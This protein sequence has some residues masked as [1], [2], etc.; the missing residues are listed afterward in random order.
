[1]RNSHNQVPAVVEYD[2]EVDVADKEVELVALEVLH[3]LFRYFAM[4]GA[5]VGAE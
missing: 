4:Q 2:V 3:D 5:A 1:M